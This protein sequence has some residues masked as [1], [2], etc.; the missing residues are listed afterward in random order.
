[1]VFMENSEAEKFVR[2]K[3]EKTFKYF[4]KLST[5]LIVN[6]KGKH[7]YSKITKGKEIKFK[8]KIKL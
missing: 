8:A 2:K 7:L 6:K 1:M 4:Q 3:L 5:I